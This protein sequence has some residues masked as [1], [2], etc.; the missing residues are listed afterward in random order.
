MAIDAYVGR[1]S[2]PASGAV[3]PDSARI[4]PLTRWDVDSVTPAVSHRPGSRFG[5]YARGSLAA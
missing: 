5:R 4:T 3:A 2:E 1:F